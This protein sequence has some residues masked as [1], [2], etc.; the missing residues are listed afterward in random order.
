METKREMLP[1]VFYIMGGSGRKEAF[2]DETLYPEKGREAIKGFL[3]NLKTTLETEEISSMHNFCVVEDPFT[4]QPFLKIMGASSDSMV[5]MPIGGAHAKDLNDLFV[6]I[7][8]VK[9]AWEL[10]Q[11]WDYV[12]AITYLPEEQ[13]KEWSDTSTQDQ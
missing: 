11:N 5:H 4:F 7:D 9:D 13:I 1:G 3:D 10:T 2:L 6:I 12:D 8:F